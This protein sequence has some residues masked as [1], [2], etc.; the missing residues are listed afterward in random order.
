M[1]PV[2]RSLLP[3]LSLL[4]LALAAAGCAASAKQIASLR[5]RADAGDQE[6]QLSLAK[7]YAEG[8][9]VDPDA[10]QAAALYR[11]AAEA[12]NAEGQLA[13]GFAYREGVGVAQDDQLALLWTRKA[14]DAGNPR[15][16]YLLGLAYAD[17]AGVP[18]DP[19]AA[20]AWFN[21]AA[22]GLPPEEGRLAVRERDWLTGVMTPAQVAE[23]QRLAREWA[24][25]R[26]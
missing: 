4:A 26:K 18:R 9:G 13:M 15:A 20:H 17:G 14:A 5:Q 2:R 12:G 22:A 21:L 3:W 6:A 7:K 19:V 25:K 23:A 1:H 10:V 16:Q 8:D 24:Q 11:K